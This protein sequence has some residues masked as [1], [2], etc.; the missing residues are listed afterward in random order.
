MAKKNAHKTPA[1]LGYTHMREACKRIKCP[2][3][4]GATADW[5]RKTRIDHG[6]ERPH[7]HGLWRAAMRRDVARGQMLLAQTAE[8]T[9]APWPVERPHW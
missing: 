8:K 1:A 3:C 4:N 9:P 5:L 2:A 6:N 7:G